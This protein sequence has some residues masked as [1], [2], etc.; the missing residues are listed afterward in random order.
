[1]ELNFVA[2]TKP[3][4]VSV[5]VKRRQRLVQR[6]DQQIGYCQAMRAGQSPRAAWTWMDE[7]GTYFV[8]IK[9][10]RQQIEL[11]KGMFSVRCKDID[12]CENAFGTIRAM[13]LNGDFDQQLT[14]ASGEIRKRF[15]GG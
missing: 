7:A 1:M 9:Y 8:P 6:I 5:A 10:G 11:K 3:T 13:V 4:Q 14:K 2:D 12:E 15:A